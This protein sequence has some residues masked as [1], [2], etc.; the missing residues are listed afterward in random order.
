MLGD[1]MMADEASHFRYQT[2]ADSAD[3]RGIV[4]PPTWS[5]EDIE[6]EVQGSQPAQ[7]QQQP[8]AGDLR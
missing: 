8:N 3:S 5:L 7:Y 6:R 2:V 1:G 4:A